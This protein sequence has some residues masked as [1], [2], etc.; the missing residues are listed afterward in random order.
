MTLRRLMLSLLAFVRD[1]VSDY[2]FPAPDGERTDCRVFLHGLPEQQDEGTYP[3]VIVRWREGEIESMEDAKTVLRETVT[4]ILG[5]HSPKSQGEA[6]ILCAELLDALRRSLWKKRILD[7][8]F[9]LMEPLRSVMPEA[10]RQQHHYHLAA[11][12]T[13]WNY[14]WPPKALEEAGQSQIRSGR[15]RANSYSETD[16]AQ[17]GPELK[18]KQ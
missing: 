5:V 13:V 7:N 12:D 17:A 6:G 11:I 14:I 4:L 15:A 3:F 8:R 16:L 2:S 9:E 18:E 1:S 10:D